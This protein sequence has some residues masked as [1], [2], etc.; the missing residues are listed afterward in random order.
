MLTIGALL[1]A[2]LVVW[3]LTRTV[4]PAPAA[5]LSTAETAATETNAP[6]ETAA[7]ETAAG[8]AAPPAI[9]TAASSGFNSPLTPAGITPPAQSPDKAEVTRIAA[10]DLQE[11]WKAGNV[12]VVDVRDALSFEA[13]HIPGAL[14]MP[15][16]SVE[17]N[18][19]LLPKG[20]PIV[21][22]CT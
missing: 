5:A 21:T 1:V 6:I 16:A 2:G 8:S 20:K 3:A 13:G 9:D 4:E 18:L 11:K 10:E 15:L 14:N 12:T 19:D 7:L 17:A 22:Y